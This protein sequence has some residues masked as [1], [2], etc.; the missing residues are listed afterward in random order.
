[1]IA[2]SL[3]YLGDARDVP[4][5]V[6]SLLNTRDVSLQIPIAEGFGMH[7]TRVSLEAVIE[8]LDTE[9]LPA[10][11]QGAALEAIGLL[12]GESPGR[13]LTE[14]FHETNFDDLPSWVWR[15]RGL[16]L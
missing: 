11:T 9:D 7:G 16:T 4:A 10:G 1:M 2:H 6:D 8:V 5:M 13:V 14:C 12:L 3:G 15:L